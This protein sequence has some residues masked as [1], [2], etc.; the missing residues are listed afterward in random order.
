MVMTRFHPAVIALALCLACGPSDPTTP[1]AEAPTAPPETTGGTSLELQL[2]PL[3]DLYY[4]V[5]AQAAD[6]DVE[7]TPGYEAAVEAA[8]AIQQSMGSFGGWGPLD[9]QVFLAADPEVLVEGFSELPEPYERRGREISIRDDAV[10]LATAIQAVMPEFTRDL[11]PDR[12]AELDRRI[13]YLETHFMPGHRKALFFMM[14]SLGIPDLGLTVP[15][16]LVNATN[17]PGAMTYHLR[18]GAP[19]CVIDVNVGGAGDLLLETILHESSHTLDM[20]SRDTGSAFATLRSLLEESGLSR[21]DDAYHTVP[22]TLMFVQAEET[23]RR[24]FNPDHLAYGDAT[25]LYERTGVTAVVER[26]TWPR[27]LDGELSRD[28]ALRKIVETLE[29]QPDD[30]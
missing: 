30:N 9:S 26:E 1:S 19:A 11:W 12:K 7:P 23:M 14:Q 6:A 5:R 17:P 18:G 28:E 15:V 13:A 20:A 22:H 21:R 2:S 4:Y 27:Y 8:R 16:F 29:P 25:D 10:R 24:L 3:V